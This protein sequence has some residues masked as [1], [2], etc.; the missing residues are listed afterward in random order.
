MCK[1][2]ATPTTVGIIYNLVNK[3]RGRVI[4]E[5]VIEGTQDLSLRFLVPLNES[6]MFT[7]EI[8]SK[9]QGIAYP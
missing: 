5:Y 6:F 7:Q 3:A 8:L 9:C 4:D 1:L 2:E